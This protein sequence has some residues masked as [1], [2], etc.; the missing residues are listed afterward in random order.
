MANALAY[1]TSI[2]RLGT[3]SES[4]APKS[5]DRAFLAD[6]KLGHKQCLH[7][8]RLAIRLC[9]LLWYAS[10]VS[11]PPSDVIFA[12]LPCPLNDVIFVYIENN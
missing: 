10:A 6:I 11:L 3:F 12:Q 5:A 2:T 1:N 7:R 4:G 9:L 8:D